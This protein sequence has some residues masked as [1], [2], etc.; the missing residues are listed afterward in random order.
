[1]SIS[2]R[3]LFGKLNSTLFKGLESAATYCKLRG[4]PYIELVHW[5]HQL[6]QVNNSDMHLIAAH[7]GLHKETLESDMLA[8]IMALPSGAGSISDFS[9]HIEHVIERSWIEASLSQSDTQI[10]SAWLIC[11]IT[12]SNELRR[13]LYGISHEFKKIDFAKIKSELSLIIKDSAE[14]DEKAHD[15]LGMV[16]AEPGE[17]SDAISATHT[18]KKSAL[19]TYCTDL[20]KLA[21]ENKIDPVIGRSQEIQ[22][23]IDILLRRRQ[24]NPL[25]TGEAGVGKTAVIEGL[26][27][28]I[29]SGQVPPS[30]HQVRLLSLDMGALIA[31]ASMRGEFESRLKD[32]L[33]EAIESTV[34]VM[35]F[36]DEIHTIVGAGDHSGT[37]DAANLLKPALARGGLRTIGATTWSE[38]KKYIEKDPALTRRFQVIQVMEPDEAKAIEMV[39]GIADTF[40]NHHQIRILDEAVVAAVRL[41][42]RYIPARQLPD[43][44]ISLLDTACARV[45]MSRY[46]PPSEIIFLRQQLLALETEHTFLKNQALH[47]V[48]QTEKGK[49]V[50]DRINQLETSLTELKVKLEKQQNNWTQELKL[51]EQVDASLEKIN[52]IHKKQLQIEKNENENEN[53]IKLKK[54]QDEVSQTQIQLEFLQQET[55]GLVFSSVDESVVGA[56]VSE[57]TSIPVGRM[58]KNDVEAILGLQDSLARRVKGQDHALQ[59]ICKRLRMSKAKITDPNKPIGVFM[60]VGPSGVGKTETALALAENLYGGEQNLITINMSEFQEPHTVSTLKGSPPGYVGY[61]EGGILTEAVRRRPYSVVLLDEVE[62][63]HHDVLEVFFQV[64]DK[65]WMEDGEGRYIDFKNTLI[66]LTSN[67][68]EST[69]NQLC[70]DPALKP[71]SEMLIT[72]LAPELRQHF[73]TAFLGRLT[74]IPYLS[75][76]QQMLSSIIDLQLNRIIDRIKFQH[77][78]ALEIDPAVIAHIANTCGRHET[79]ARRIHQYIDQNILPEI[80]DIWLCNLEKNPSI[81]KIKIHLAQRST[82]NSMPLEVESKNSGLIFK[83]E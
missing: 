22:T 43:K 42:H 25:L 78:I 83:V 12:D 70:E 62:K 38:Y 30:L 74:V 40:S 69:I 81:K 10:R 27:L 50:A 65:G 32:L 63:A 44:A 66:L 72:S 15:Q 16:D 17:A 33:K 64:F 14:S 53:E 5:L 11:A 73:A 71:D 77:N 41:S 48:R 31:G 60:L 80:S 29:V 68:G 67:V 39:R 35:L 6:W 79:G 2:R 47:D 19:E 61:G 36:I 58:L 23:I 52:S 26:A 55:G 49:S 54:L 21:R 9:H 45:A 51:I 28:A 18:K 4:N 75:L 76:Q 20:T 82:D 34:P 56:I 59:Q 13:V 8:A 37:G 3:K 57:W 46:S 24:N 1:M 7:F